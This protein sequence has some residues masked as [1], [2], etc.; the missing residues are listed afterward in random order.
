MG[1]HYRKT[2]RVKVSS[3][4]AIALELYDK[5]NELR[6]YGRQ[7]SEIEG[8]IL[9][10]KKMEKRSFKTLD[11]LLMLMQTMA[12]LNFSATVTILGNNNKHQLL[13]FAFM[14]VNSKWAK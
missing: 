9:M 12:N 5:A 1:E 2:S 10:G 13:T 11:A 6:E 7:V 14:A 8:G 4:R 3:L